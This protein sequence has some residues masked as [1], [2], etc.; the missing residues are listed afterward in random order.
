MLCV[1]ERD[2]WAV[3][4]GADTIVVSDHWKLV[5]GEE[6]EGGVREMTGQWLLFSQVV[7]GVILEKPGSASSA[8]DMLSK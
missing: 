3:V 7:D 6:G 8:K 1:Q 4:V 2:D 5:G